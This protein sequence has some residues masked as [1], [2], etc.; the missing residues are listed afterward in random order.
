MKNSLGL[1]E[2]RS[3]AAGIKAADEMLKSAD[4]ELVMATP[5]CPGKYV[6]LITGNVGAVKNAMETGV[7]EADVFLVENHIIN[8]VDE[9]VIPALS[10]TSMI[11]DIKAIGVIETISALTSVKAGDIAVKTSNVEIIEIRIARGLG[12]KGFIII[13]GELSAVKSAIKSCVAELQEGGQIISTSVMASPD[14]GLISKI[15]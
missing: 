2:L 7:R 12:G 13:C 6:V 10:G 4:V 15:I 11:D 8:N 14:K 1:L 5:I 9:K 3:I